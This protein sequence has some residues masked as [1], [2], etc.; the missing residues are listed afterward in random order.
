MAEPTRPDEVIRY[1]TLAQVGLE[2]VA[3]IAVGL[4][5][6]YQLETLPWI[7]VAGAV[8][9]FAGGLYHLVAIL[10]RKTKP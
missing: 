6:D 8:I 5:L 4:L 2:M 3:P 10:N 7:T 9:G 1:A